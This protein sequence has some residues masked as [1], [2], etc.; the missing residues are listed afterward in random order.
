M[1]FADENQ[2]LPSA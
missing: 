2:K 1:I